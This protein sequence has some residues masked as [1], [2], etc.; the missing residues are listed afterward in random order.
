LSRPK[1]NN[2]EKPKNEGQKE[3]KERKKETKV[4]AN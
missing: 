4:N 1:E 3:R 2:E